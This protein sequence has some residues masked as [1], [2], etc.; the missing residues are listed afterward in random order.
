MISTRPPTFKSSSPFN[1]PLLTVPNA[2]ITVGII[3]T[4]MFLSFVLFPS[5][6]EIL[7][8]LFTFFQF[9]SLVSRDSKVHN[10]KNSPF[11]LLIIIRSG[12]Q[13]EIRGSVWMSKSHRSLC[14][15][16][17]RTDVM[18][19]MWLMVSSL[20]PQSVHL[21]YCIVLSILALTWLVLTALFFAAIRRDSVSLLNHEKSIN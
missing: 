2:S 17:S 4:F 1:N 21:L 20:S 3:V 13:A 11:F 6:V 8:L 12:L 14:V 10:F 15:L 9:Y 5:N 16:F 7:I 18:I 19:I